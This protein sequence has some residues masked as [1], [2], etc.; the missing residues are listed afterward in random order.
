M[1]IISKEKLITESVIAVSSE[2][3]LGQ[4]AKQ[5]NLERKKKEKKNNCIDTSSDKLGKYAHEVT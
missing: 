1:I 2:I 4:A 3:T 5:Q